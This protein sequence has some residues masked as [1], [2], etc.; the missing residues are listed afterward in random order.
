ML[1]YLP[2]FLV[3]ADTFVESG[4]CCPEGPEGDAGLNEAAAD[5]VDRA[6]ADGPG[7]E[8]AAPVED[9][10]LTQPVIEIESSPE[11]CKREPCIY[12]DM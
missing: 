1:S 6:L 4:L 3:E 12:L 8:M 11:K 7:P 9:A 2:A 10:P 5:D